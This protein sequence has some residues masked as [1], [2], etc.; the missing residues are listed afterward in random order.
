MFIEVTV[1]FKNL[2]RFFLLPYT[3]LFRLYVLY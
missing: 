1:G 2:A 3:S